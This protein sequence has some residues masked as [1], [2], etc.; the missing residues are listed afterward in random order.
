MRI[1]CSQD[2]SRIQATKDLIAF[3]KLHGLDRRG[4]R[5]NWEAD[6]E[7]SEKE[8]EEDPSW[9]IPQ[10]ALQSSSTQISVEMNGFSSSSSDRHSPG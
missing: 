3:S 10:L 8:K 9:Y 5:V 7:K 2:I 1:S 6:D 4:E